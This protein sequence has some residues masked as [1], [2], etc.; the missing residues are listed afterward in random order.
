MIRP[1]PTAL[2]ELQQQL[3]VLLVDARDV[4]DERGYRI[5][6]DYLCAIAAREAARCTNWERRHEDGS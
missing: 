6:V 1:R 5:F 4:L 3:A 2:Q